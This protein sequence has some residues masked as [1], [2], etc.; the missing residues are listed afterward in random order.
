M[1]IRMVGSG[2]RSNSLTHFHI[3]SLQGQQHRD[4]GRGDGE[5]QDH[6]TDPVSARGRL[7]QLRYGGLHPAPQGGCHERGQESQRG[8]IQQPRSGGEDL[9]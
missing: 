5:W 3:C 9:D 2:G 8:D 7:H 1:D 6:A 4:R